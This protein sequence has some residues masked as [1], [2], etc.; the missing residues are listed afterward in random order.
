[1]KQ[2]DKRIYSYIKDLDIEKVFKEHTEFLDLIKEYKEILEVDTLNKSLY[3]LLEHIE[4]NTEY[5]VRLDTVSK[6]AYNISL[7]RDNKSG[8]YFPLIYLYNNTTT[9]TIVGDSG[10]RVILKFYKKEKQQLNERTNS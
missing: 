1:M 6:I 7:Y 4:V 8:T 5:T 3:Y 9:K 2:I 10:V